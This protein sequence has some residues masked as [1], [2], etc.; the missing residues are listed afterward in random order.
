[1]ALPAQKPESRPRATATSVPDARP[2]L[3]LSGPKLKAALETLVERAEESGG[4]ERYVDAVRLKGELFARTL[5]D[6]RAREAS[7][8]DFRALCA[9]MSTVRRR[10]GAYVEPEAFEALR[11]R[12]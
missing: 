1:M 11:T 7:L 2:R 5:G 3:E 10:I 4:V 12:V 8:A 6:G 9:C